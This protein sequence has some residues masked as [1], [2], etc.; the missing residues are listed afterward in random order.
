M[1]AAAD[2]DPG[3]RD[4][5]LLILYLTAWYGYMISLS[6]LRLLSQKLT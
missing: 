2:P 3:I 6:D 1:S 4:R 5:T